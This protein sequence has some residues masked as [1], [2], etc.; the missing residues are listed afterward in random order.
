MLI[1]LTFKERHRP[2]MKQVLPH[3]W[4]HGGRASRRQTLSKQQVQGLLS[5][6]SANA[7]EQAV[8][9]DVASHI[10][11]EKL[12]ELA[13]QFES[14]SQG[15][16]VLLAATIAKATE[17]AGLDPESAERAAQ[18]FARHGPV[19][20]S[21]FVAAMVPTCD[22]S[23]MKEHLRDAFQRLDNNGDGFV[24]ASDVRDMLDEDGV[25]RSP[26]TAATANSMSLAMPGGTSRISFQ[27]FS[28]AFRLYDEQA[29]S[30]PD[31]TPP[32]H[33]TGGRRRRVTMLCGDTF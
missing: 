11:L 32:R 4:L 1:M 16:G 7:F 33:S 23:V 5:F 3:Q 25:R 2:S 30:K 14:F 17:E 24:T 26:Y 12:K 10:P 18:Q 19:E 13:Q 21:R 9:Y 31:A 22:N 6:N 27:T 20:F 29:D 28:K 8:L 15:E